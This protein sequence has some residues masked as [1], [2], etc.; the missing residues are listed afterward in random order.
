MSLRS[1]TCV[2]PPY[3]PETPVEWLMSLL[4]NNLRLDASSLAMLDSEDV[5]QG[6]KFNFSTSI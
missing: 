3:H 2:E 4:L 1:L 5:E 6:V